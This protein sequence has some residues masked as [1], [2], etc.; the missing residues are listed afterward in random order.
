MLN[1]SLENDTGTKKTVS[2]STNSN[3]NSNSNNNNSKKSNKVK[4]TEL[5]TENE[6]NGPKPKKENNKSRS[7]SKEPVAS[8]EQ[9]NSFLTAAI[10]LALPTDNEF[11]L[12]AG[13]MEVFY[14]QYLLP[15]T[16]FWLCKYLALNV[17]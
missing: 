16:I 2:S 5:S 12:F 4:A 9:D 6:G 14:P 8:I 1:S 7:K 11:S 15:F 17:L 10:D 3:G 13:D